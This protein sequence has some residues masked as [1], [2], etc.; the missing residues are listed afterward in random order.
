MI[1]LFSKISLLEGLSLLLLLF[2]AMPLKYLLGMAQVVSIV[3]MVHGIL[4]LI[5]LA[6]SLI[7]AHK[8][9]WSLFFYLWAL[10]CAV[11][12]FGFIALNR[13]LKEDA[14]LVSSNAQ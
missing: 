1:P 13:H 7:A 12:P 9:K 2:V 14:M 5:Y 10:L 3:G 4:F 11:I 6:F 8:A